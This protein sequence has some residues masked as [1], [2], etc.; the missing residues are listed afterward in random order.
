MIPITPRMK[1]ETS[2]DELLSLSLL[3]EQEGVRLLR[4]RSDHSIERESQARLNFAQ[5]YNTLRS[6]PPSSPARP[7]S[8]LENERVSPQV[9]T[10]FR[11]AAASIL[12]GVGSNGR[13]EATRVKTMQ[14]S[15]AGDPP[16]R[17]ILLATLTAREREGVDLKAATP[18]GTRH[19]VFDYWYAAAALSLD[20]EI[21]SDRGINQL[22]AGHRR[23]S[24]GL[25]KH[26]RHDSLSH[27]S[28]LVLLISKGVLEARR[29]AQSSIQENTR[30]LSSRPDRRV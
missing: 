6:L 15:A 29:S 12:G 11:L 17:A 28:D 9:E 26:P 14:A 16:L 24:E 23:C 22:E 25:A 3:Y 2:A 20:E 5:A 19:E 10:L 13:Q 27:L 8:F 30:A 7:P 18:A 21:A 4:A 1:K